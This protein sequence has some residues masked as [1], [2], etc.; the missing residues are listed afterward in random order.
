M[1]NNSRTKPQVRRL[2]PEDTKKKTPI[3]LASLT[4]IFTLYSLNLSCCYH[5]IE[6]D[7]FEGLLILVTHMKEFKEIICKRMD[8][9]EHFTREISLEY[10]I[11][12]FTT[13]RI[14]TVLKYQI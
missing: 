13:R 8:I 6:I 12:F 9:G 11:Y 1:P 5:P 14:L 10:H 3:G 4:L 2:D 7:P